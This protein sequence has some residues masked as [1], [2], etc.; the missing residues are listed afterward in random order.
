MT[1][2]ETIQKAMELGIPAQIARHYGYELHNLVLHKRHAPSDVVKLIEEVEYLN[3]Q[4]SG[5]SAT[6]AMIF[7]NLKKLVKQARLE[8]DNVD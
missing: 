5:L 2:E 7:K 6:Q 8:I 1:Q 4:S 3:Q